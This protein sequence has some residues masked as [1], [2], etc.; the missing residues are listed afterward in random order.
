MNAK[1]CTPPGGHPSNTYDIHAR[2]FSD[3]LFDDGFESGD[4]LWW[5]AT[6]GN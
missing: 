3:L 4:T 6:V 2:L 5:S 1:G